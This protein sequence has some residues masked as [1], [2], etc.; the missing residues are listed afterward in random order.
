V[1]LPV[2]PRGW[3]GLP[4]LAIPIPF[5]ESLRQKDTCVLV[6][7]LHAHSI[8]GLATS[9]SRKRRLFLLKRR[10]RGDGQPFTMLRT[11]S[12][13]AVILFAMRKTC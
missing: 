10:L 8:L 1:G 3:P 5:R 7:F 9:R 12:V 11:Q 6:S 2:S 4:S 13:S